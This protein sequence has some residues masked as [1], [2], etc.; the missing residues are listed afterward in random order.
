MTLRKRADDK[1][2]S[3]L[4]AAPDAMVIVDS[5]GKI[6]LVNAQTE[7]LFGYT[8]W[9]LMGREVECLIPERYRGQHLR[10][11]AGFFA[12]RRV[13]PMGVA[14]ELFGLRKDDSEFPVE[15]SLSPMTTEEGMVV[16]GAIR[17]V[18]ERKL[19]EEQIKKL[20]HVAQHD[21][22]T[23]LPNRTLL[24]DRIAQAMAM[25]ERHHKKLAVLFVDLDRFK[26]I[27]DSLGH[28]TGDAVLQSI[29]ERLRK[30][31]RHAD[32]VSR[33]GGDEFVVLLPEID[34]ANDAALVAEKMLAA[35]AAPHL[36]G[37]RELS[38]P[39]SIGISLYPDHGQDAEGLVH[40]A[41]VAMYKAK[42]SGG[43]K[44]LFAEA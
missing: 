14:L 35:L 42:Q 6:T 4:E 3:L 22:L 44:Y 36:A 24:T 39:A 38:V 34:S 12:E 15:I 27:N 8:R 37:G 20:N 25:A 5:A 32:T 41:D 28:A 23:G 18:T 31:L 33:Q 30:T 43:C 29:A 21:F 26:P 10:H 17:D 11:R 9:E 1:F 40:S 13:R 2:R 19:V 16:I 7:K